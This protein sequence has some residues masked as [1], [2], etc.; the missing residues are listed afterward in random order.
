LAVLAA[1]RLDADRLPEL[2]ADGDRE[3]LRILVG[4]RQELAVASTGQTNGYARRR[5]TGPVFAA[6]TKNDKAVYVV[7]AAGK[8]G[9]GDDGA[10]GHVGPP[11]SALSPS[12]HTWRP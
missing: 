10:P 9:A 8:G 12:R 2:R 7:L 11:G 6:T 1:L 3:A 5:L 4:A